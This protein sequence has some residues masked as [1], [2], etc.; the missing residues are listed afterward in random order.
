[1]NRTSEGWRRSVITPCQL[2]LRRLYGRDRLSER[3]GEWV[4]N[5]ESFRFTHSQ[6]IRPDVSERHPCLL[7]R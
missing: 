2:G 4:E 6:F 1:M 3:S 7:I 5:G